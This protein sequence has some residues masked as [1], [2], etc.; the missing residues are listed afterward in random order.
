MNKKDSSA[1]ISAVGDISFSGFHHKFPSGDVF[2][3][4]RNYLQSPYLVVGNL[5]CPL[6]DQGVPVPGK[7]TLKGNPGWADILKEH[8]IRLVSLANNHMMDFGEQGLVSTISSLDACGIKYAGAGSNRTEAC[9]PVYLKI[10]G[11]TI[12]FLAR[13]S[14]IVS[15]PCYAGADTAGIAFFDLNETISSINKCKESSDIVIVSLHWG[16]EEYTY[17]TPFQVEQ[18]KHLVC[19]GA[20]VVL[21]HHPHILQGIQRISGGMVAYSLGNFLFDDFQWHR[22]GGGKDGNI[23]MT[24]TEENKKGMILNL[25]F[26]KDKGIEI[27]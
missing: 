16:L 27:S 25:S 3:Q 2:Q 21:G 1:N 4:V 23:H 5:E 18:A 8:N 7:C 10:K 13:S 20:D 17:P 12:A 19:S 15:S 26:Q 11:L 6:V 14:V 9:S 24:L 22:Q